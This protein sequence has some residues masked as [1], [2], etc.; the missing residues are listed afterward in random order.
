MRLLFKWQTLAV[1]RATRKVLS[2]ITDTVP[3]LVHF[4]LRCF[5]D[6][7]LR[8]IKAQGGDVNVVKEAK[9]LVPHKSV[10]LCRIEMDM[11]EA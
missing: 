11:L 7:L 2:W 3:C 5:K 9:I 6:Q 1:M 4:E 8:I 10:N